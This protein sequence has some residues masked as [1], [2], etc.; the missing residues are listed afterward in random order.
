MPGVVGDALGGIVVPADVGIVPVVVVPVG[1][2][3]VGGTVFTVDSV[4]S[5]AV[6]TV[7]QKA[8]FHAMLQP[9]DCL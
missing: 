3:V 8:H 9:F 4:D 5:R 6:V 2:V 7:Q 1:S